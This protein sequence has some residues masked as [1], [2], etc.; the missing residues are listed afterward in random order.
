MTASRKALNASGS[1]G[2][3]SSLAL[4][5]NV[6]TSNVARYFRLWRGSNSTPEKGRGSGKLTSTRCLTIVRENRDLAW[7]RYVFTLV[8][9]DRCEMGSGAAIERNERFHC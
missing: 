2:V 3:S 6:C 4:A 5:I 8:L 9:A 1:Q 7:R